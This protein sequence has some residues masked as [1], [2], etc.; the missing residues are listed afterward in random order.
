FPTENDASMRPSAETA[1]TKP[2]PAEAEEEGQMTFDGLDEAH[3]T[4]LQTL[5]RGET[6]EEQI[7]SAHLMP[8]LVVDTINEAFYDEIGDNILEY[9]GNEISLIE[10]YR[11]DVAAILGGN[12]R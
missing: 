9:D 6:A 4:I 7:R 2:A 11:E 12:A 3:L 10:D 8:A 1:V 5:L